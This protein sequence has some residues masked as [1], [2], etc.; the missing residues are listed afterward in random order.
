MQIRLTILLVLC[1]PSAWVCIQR[2]AWAQEPPGEPVAERRASTPENLAHALI[3][4]RAAQRAAERKARL[5]QQHLAGHS[6]LRPNARP[7]PTLLND[8]AIYRIDYGMKIERADVP[9]L[10]HADLQPRR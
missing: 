5:A 4:D 3:T 7:A 2:D 1:C 9:F 10:M 6:F 8:P